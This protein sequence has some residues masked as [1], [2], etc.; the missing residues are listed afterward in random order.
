[1]H[2]VSTRTV[3]TV[4]ISAIRPG[5]E[6]G[7][8]TLLRTRSNRPPRA[9]CRCAFVQELMPYVLFFFMNFFINTPL[10]RAII[11]SNSKETE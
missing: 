4:I 1:M 5:R 2:S 10:A 3:S 8:P 6:S 9:L 7:R 11:N